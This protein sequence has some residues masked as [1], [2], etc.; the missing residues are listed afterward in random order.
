MVKVG[1]HC[2]NGLEYILTFYEEVLFFC[3]ADTEG[4]FYEFCIIAKKKKTNKQ[5]LHLILFN[6]GA[7]FIQIVSF[8]YL[9]CA[10]YQGCKS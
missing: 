3:F 7:E 10:L 2:L 8:S 9:Q 1:K 6:P 5:N 4:F